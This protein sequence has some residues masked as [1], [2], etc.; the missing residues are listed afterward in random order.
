MTSVSF[1][2]LF[3]KVFTINPV[4]FT[5]FGRG[6]RWYGILICLAILLA[7]WN[8]VVCAKK[9]GVSSDDVMDYALWVI[10][11]AIVGARLYYVLTSLDKYD[12]FGEA[13]AIWNGGIAIYGAV[14]GGALATLIVSRFKKIKFP[15]I[16]D[17]IASS[18]LL[19]QAIGRWGNFCNGEAYGHLDRFELLGRVFPTPS[20]EKDFFLR[21]TVSS[22]ATRGAL[23]TVHPTFLYESVWNLAGFV[24]LRL[25]YRNKKF[26][27]QIILTYVVW[28]GFGRFFIEG[29]RDDSLLLWGTNVRISQ[30]LALVSFLVCAVLLAVFLI[31]GKKQPEAVQAAAAG[32]ENAAEA[33]ESEQKTE[34]DA[35]EHGEVESNT[36]TDTESTEETKNGDTH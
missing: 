25:L 36:P 18:L 30:L 6:I 20:F 4:A 16:A 33:A 11:C 28:Y 14:L 32:G 26:D 34:K 17:A 5:V 1:P 35:P 8:T 9:E 15:K 19:G 7:V 13:I 31:R 3:E 12:S 24:L 23:L 27:G 22:E 21:M 10:P 2:G 29:L